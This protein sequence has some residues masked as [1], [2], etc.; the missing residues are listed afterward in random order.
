MGD[1]TSS[2]S[3]GEIS[4]LD[5]ELSLRRV[6]AAKLAPEYR[7]LKAT[8]PARASPSAS[9]WHSDLLQSFSFNATSKKLALRKYSNDL[10]CN[11][12]I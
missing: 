7:R 6:R 3:D 5:A 1:R 8:L 10:D 4:A 2:T 11:D 9:R 12:I